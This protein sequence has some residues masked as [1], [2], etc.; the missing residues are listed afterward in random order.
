MNLKT[1]LTFA[2][3]DCT[4]LSELVIANLYSKKQALTHQC[5][6]VSGLEKEFLSIYENGQEFFFDMSTIIL[7]DFS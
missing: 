6:L 2:G 1:A 7:L 5:H 4:S 3:S